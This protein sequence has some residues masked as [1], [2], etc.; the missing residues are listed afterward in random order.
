M[1]CLRTLA[2]GFDGQR[3]FN[4]S[5]AFSLYRVLQLKYASTGNSI[6]KVYLSMTCGKYPLLIH[7]YHL[8]FMMTSP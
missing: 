8:P 5:A 1:C 3:M 2:V 6:F 7:R 4:F